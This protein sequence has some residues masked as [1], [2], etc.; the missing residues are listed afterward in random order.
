MTYRGLLGVVVAAAVW[1]AAGQADALLYRCGPNLCRA[2]PD[3]S[4][5]RA[6]TRDGQP[7]GPSYGWLSASAD[8]SRVAVVKATFAYVLDA[9]G[10]A[11]TGPLPRGGTVVIAELS[12]DGTQIATVEL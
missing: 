12:P 8:G 11:V 6:I 3:G 7:G 5:Q 4:G 1:P 2:A 9:N 10:R